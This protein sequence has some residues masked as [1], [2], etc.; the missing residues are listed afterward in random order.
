[1]KKHRVLIPLDGTNFRQKI[2]PVVRQFFDP[3]DTEFVLLRVAPFSSIPRTAIYYHDMCLGDVAFLTC[4]ETDDPSTSPEQAYRTELAKEL[5]EDAIELREA[6]YSVCTA[7]R[8][9]DPVQ[10]IVEYVNFVQIDLIA[11]ATHCRTG[12]SRIVQGSIAQEV[13][14]NVSTPVMMLRPPARPTFRRHTGRS[15]KLHAA[16]GSLTIEQTA[17]LFPITSQSSPSSDP[18]YKRASFR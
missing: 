11:M 15:G 5:E 1:M 9:G 7:V 10:K 6:G 4:T 2:V 18:P 12:I 3:E 17:C 14:R 8:L 16:R 13:L